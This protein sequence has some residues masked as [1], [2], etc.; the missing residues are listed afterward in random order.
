MRYLIC[1]DLH[2][3]F[4]IL[5]QVEELSKDYDKVIF[6]GDYVDDWNAIP[7]ASYNTVKE[8]IDFKLTN[9]DKVVLLLGNHSFSEW[10]GRPFLASGNNPITHKLVEPLYSDNEELFN[11]AYVPE[12][13]E[14]LV[15]HAGLT[16]RWWEKYFSE[17]PYEGELKAK[18]YADALNWAFHHRGDDVTAEEAF[19]GFADVGYMRGGHSEPSPIWADSNELILDGIGGLPQVVGHT[20]FS[21]VTFYENPNTELYFCDTH[22]TYRDGTNIGDNSLLVLEGF[23]FYKIGL[24]GK[25]LPW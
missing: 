17:L 23:R 9:P 15:T 2:T 5:K 3:H 18:N 12:G 4:D 24:D 6:L 22:S 25:K 16:Y 19:Y 11:I 10:F 8:L 13:I 14:V 7:E 21:T 1:G 20:P